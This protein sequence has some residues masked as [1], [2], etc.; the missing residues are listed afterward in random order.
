MTSHVYEIRDWIK[1][2]LRDIFCDSNLGGNKDIIW[3]GQ[4]S[5]NMQTKIYEYKNL[6]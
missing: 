5:K 6:F 4:L 1:R 2:K 3:S